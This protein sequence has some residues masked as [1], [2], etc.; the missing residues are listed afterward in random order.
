MKC[1][2]VATIFPPINGGSAVVYEGI[3]QFSPAGSMQVL[4]PWR[5]YVDGTEVPGW[6]EY[7]AAAG[8]PIERI[9]LLRPPMVQSRSIWHSC[10][11][12]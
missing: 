5:H 8:F 12:N 6:R 1:L 2:L 10:G 3:C 9:E 4:A 7:D 11:C